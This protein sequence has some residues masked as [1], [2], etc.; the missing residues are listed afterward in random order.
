MNAGVQYMARGDLAAARRYFAHARTLLPN[1]A[2][3]YMNLSVLETQEGHLAE[4][5]QAAQQGV[6]LKPAL[7]LTH[8]Y[9]GQVFEKLGRRD[10]A[11]SAYQQGLAVE[12]HHPSLQEAVE[13]LSQS[14]TE[15]LEAIM[16]AGLDA[17]YKDNKPH[18]AITQFRKVLALLPTHY[19]ATYQL[20][21]ALD[22]AGTPDEAR[23]LWAKMREMAEAIN[24]QHTANTARARLQEQP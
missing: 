22:A 24:D 21:V 19:G 5:L 3:L 1:Y 7:A 14:R 16:Q 12:P 23:Q 15:S 8:Y 20:A 2:Y 10:D 11:W 17:L 18:Q 9:L 6:R 4:A 13:Q